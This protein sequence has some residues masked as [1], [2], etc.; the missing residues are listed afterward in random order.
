MFIDIHGR[1]VKTPRFL[2]KKAAKFYGEYL[3]GKKLAEN[4]NLTI[5][6]QRFD[7]GSRDY[8][9]CDW[10]DDNHR[11]R[12]FIIT[13]DRSLSKKETLLA[14]AHE[15]VHLKQYAKG[16]LKDIFRP[17][18]MTKWMGEMYDPKQ[19]DYWSDPWE[20]EARGMEMELYIKFLGYLK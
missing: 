7:D 11:S 12:V 2:V 14:L 10:V 15:M 3:M 8:A 19:S 1:S 18:R 6:F 13:I 5:D 20:R 16:E 4:V 17:K 9:Y